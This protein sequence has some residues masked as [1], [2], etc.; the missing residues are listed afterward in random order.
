MGA[1]NRN[2]RDQRTQTWNPLEHKVPERNDHGAKH[3]DQVPVGKGEKKKK[4]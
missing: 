3:G 2:A 4:A 1:S